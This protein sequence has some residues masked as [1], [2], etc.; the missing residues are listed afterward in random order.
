M[1]AKSRVLCSFLGYQLKKRCQLIGASLA[2][3]TKK[4][5]HP[6]YELKLRELG[7]F[8]SREEKAQGDVCK[9]LMVFMCI[10]I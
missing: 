4:L 1:I 5:E 7:C 9:Y 10:N 3:V 2:K 6:V 8:W